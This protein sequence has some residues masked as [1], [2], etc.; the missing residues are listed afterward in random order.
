[1]A[2]TDKQLTCVDCGAGFTFTSGE[3]ERFAQLGFTNEPKRC[4]SCRAAKKASRGGNGGPSA[5]R[6]EMFPAVCA[7]CGQT[8]QVPFKPRGDR[9]VYCSDCYSRSRP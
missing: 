2:Y 6:R 9:P 7:Q 5:A 1:M 4:A 3:Q 8:T